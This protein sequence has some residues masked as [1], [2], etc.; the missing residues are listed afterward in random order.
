[1]IAI[2]KL[3]GRKGEALRVGLLKEETNGAAGVTRL[4]NIEF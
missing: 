2:E 4:F 1:M 3:G